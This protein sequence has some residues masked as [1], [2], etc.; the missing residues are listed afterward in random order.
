M[1][2]FDFN[3]IIENK[4]GEATSMINIRRPN[5]YRDFKN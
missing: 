3:F 2:L 4:K 5:Q 1:Y